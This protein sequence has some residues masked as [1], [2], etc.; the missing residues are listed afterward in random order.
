[1]PYYLSN[2]TQ[3]NYFSV[4]F[5]IRQFP[6]KPR[7]LTSEEFHAQSV[8]ETTKALEELKNYCSSPE[9]KPW[10]MMTRLK[11]P[12][13]FVHTFS[14]EILYSEHLCKFFNQTEPSIY[15]SIKFHN[16]IADLRHLSK[17]VLIWR[18]MRS[19]NTKQRK[20]SETTTS[21]RVMRMIS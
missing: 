14:F 21:I 19:W 2:Q 6:P 20:L 3:I 9:S 16:S 1:M 4:I 11:D 18:T 17:V 15:F 12:Q 13:R 10:R 5:R 7:L 8:F